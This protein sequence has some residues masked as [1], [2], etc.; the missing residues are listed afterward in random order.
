MNS[1]EFSANNRAGHLSRMESDPIV[2]R[3]ESMTS[4]AS[5][6]ALLII[7]LEPTAQ[8]S[9]LPATKLAADSLSPQFRPLQSG[10]W[11]FAERSSVSWVLRLF[12]DAFGSGATSFIA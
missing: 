8:R 2:T 3:R 6:S 10:V 1:N 12:N 5:V 9:S 4:L 7:P 11:S